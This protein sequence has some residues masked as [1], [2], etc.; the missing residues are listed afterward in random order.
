LENQFDKYQDMRPLFK[1]LQNAILERDDSID[2][3]VRKSYVSLTKKR[4]FAAINIKKGEL[5]MG[6]DLGERPF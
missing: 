6:L 4:E 5:R 3:V 2:F 1:N